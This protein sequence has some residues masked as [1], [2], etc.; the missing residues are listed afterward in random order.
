VDSSCCTLF[1]GAV[2]DILPG[3]GVGSALLEGLVAY[4]PGVAY[5]S[6]TYCVE[7][8]A[9]NI[10]NNHSSLY[11][12]CSILRFILVPCCVGVCHS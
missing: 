10:I 7:P 12:T 6:G 3:V 4:K 2:A 9:T 5:F 8:I 1:L 11:C